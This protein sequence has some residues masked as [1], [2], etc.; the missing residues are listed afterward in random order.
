[1]RHRG[2]HGE[3]TQLDDDDVTSLTLSVCLS[4]LLLHVQLMTEVDVNFIKT[5][6][7]LLSLFCSAEA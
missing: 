2:K 3:C 5:V 4:V 6:M 7:L 1:M